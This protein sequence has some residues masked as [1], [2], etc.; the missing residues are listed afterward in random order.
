MPGTVAKSART[1][2]LCLG[3]ET[4]TIAYGD[5]GGSRTRNRASFGGWCPSFRRRD[6]VPGPLPAMQSSFSVIGLFARHSCRQRTPD[7]LV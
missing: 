7:E 3:M 4:T 6:Q 1:T 5:H 2:P